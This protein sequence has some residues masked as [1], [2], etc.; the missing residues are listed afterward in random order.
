MV[1]ITGERTKVAEVIKANDQPERV[2]AEFKMEVVE[3]CPDEDGDAITTSIVSIASTGSG[4]T[5]TSPPSFR[6]FL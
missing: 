3:T 2:I 1:Q 5:P 4:G 6:N